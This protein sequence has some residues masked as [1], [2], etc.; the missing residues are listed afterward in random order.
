MKQLLFN[1]LLLLSCSAASAQTA[2]AII[3]KHLSIRGA[4]ALDSVKNARMDLEVVL[5]NAPSM[6]SKATYSTV[7]MQSHRIDL[8]VPNLYET[9]I[10]FSGDQGWG[11]LKKAGKTELTRMD[12]ATVQELKYQTEILGPLYQYQE[13][14]YTV[15]YLGREVMDESVAFI[16]K[17]NAAHSTTYHCYINTQSL[18]EVKRTVLAPNNGE[19]ITVDLYFSEYKPV[20]GVLMPFKI[21]MRNR[22]GTT[23]FN[24]QQ[25]ELNTRLAPKL[26]E[27]PSEGK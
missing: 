8:H 7:M 16:L 1:C 15:E 21:E 25:I 9:V 19:M 14:G 17:V 4:D 12:S 27:I 24:F 23:Y 6:K 5:K 22:K 13:K 2:A 18:L 3:E 10:C 26:F 11:L 20:L